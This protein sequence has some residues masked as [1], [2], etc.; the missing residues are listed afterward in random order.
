[1]PSI[2]VIDDR[3]EVRDAVKARLDRALAREG[4]GDEWEVVVTPPLPSIGLYAPWV[5]EHEVAVL[6]VDQRLNEEFPT[7]YSGHD[8]V[9]RLRPR[10][11]DLPIFYLTEVNDPVL[12]EDQRVSAVIARRD[13][14]T[15]I[16]ATQEWLRVF[17][18]EGLRYEQG[19]ARA[20]ARLSEI[21]EMTVMGTA[22][23]EELKEA[24]AIRQELLLPFEGGDPNVERAQDTRGEILEA[25]GT[26]IQH[27]ESL[28]AE[29]KKIVEEADGS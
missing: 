29:L 2:G 11:F 27:L 23:E 17:M 13:L 3:E 12:E 5:T 21:S 18:R 28:A 7:P 24:A 22:N 25:F 16:D 14:T 1:M 10:K 9:D 8:I 4:A 26:E 6:L 19:V 20:L 15:D